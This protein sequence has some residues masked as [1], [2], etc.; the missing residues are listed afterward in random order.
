L[1]SVR[2]APLAGWTTAVAKSANGTPTSVTWT[3]GAGTAIGADQFGQFAMDVGPL[4]E[5]STV[6]FDVT[7]IYN[8]GSVVQWNQPPN[9]DGSEAEHPA[10]ELT[11]AATTGGTDHGGMA[12]TAAPVAEPT[13]SADTTARWLGVG[14]LLLGA[15]GLGIGVGSAS[16]SRK[17]SA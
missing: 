11:L 16:R 7:Q 10:P 2:A 15:L 6:T 13:S 4:P 17:R 12:T 3:A 1:L 9:A 5:T 14:G 8:D